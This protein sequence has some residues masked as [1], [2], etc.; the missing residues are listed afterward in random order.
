MDYGRTIAVVVLAVALAMS[1]CQAPG[2]NPDAVS[3]TEST[4][5]EGLP[6]NETDQNGT[7]GGS[8]DPFPISDPANV[9]VEGGDLRTDPGLVYTRVEGL[10]ETET[11]AP[12][13]VRAYNSTEAFGDSLPSSGIGIGQPRFF[14]VVGFET[15]AIRNE[16]FIDEVG[17]GYTLGSGSIAVFVQENATRDEEEM[18]LAHELAHYIQFQNG[19]QSQLTEE[20]DPQT[21]D[22][23]YVVRSLVEGT[24]VFTTDEYLDRFGENRTTNSPYYDDEQAAY[25][26]GHLRRWA[27]SQYQMGTDYVT[28]RLDS[29]SEVG[30]I[31]EDPPTRSRELLDPDAPQRP[32]LFVSNTLARS[33]ISTN[34]LG[35]A[36][37]RYALESHIEVDRAESVATGLGTDSLHQFRSDTDTFGNYAWATRWDSAADADRFEAAFGEYLDARGNASADGW[38]L[39]DVDLTVQLRRPTPETVVAV[40]GSDSFVEGTTASGAD[41]EIVLES[42]QK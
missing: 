21:V 19:R 37:L 36:F 24:A 34:R 4:P 41:G 32:E 27:N 35:A 39:D 5:A 8:E 13:S 6:S 31:Y 17:N 9:T 33:E 29:P 2:T 23:Q 28:Q 1:G 14:D 20:I 15:G 7:T 26:R 18:L 38:T 12:A 22:G 30:A 3:P 25:P 16:T 11:P 42:A 10:L 40:F